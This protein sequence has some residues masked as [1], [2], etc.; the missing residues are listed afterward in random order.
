MHGLSLSPS[1]NKI[2]YVNSKTI[3]FPKG[4]Q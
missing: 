2:R 1:A 4:F 3:K